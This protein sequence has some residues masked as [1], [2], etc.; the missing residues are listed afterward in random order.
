MQVKGRI[1]PYPVLNNNPVFSG[2][3]TEGFNLNYEAMEDESNYTLKGLTFQTESKI[4][5][6]LFKEKN[7]NLLDCGMFLYR[8]S[9]EV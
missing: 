2:F 3:K 6:E 4:I 1:F 9:Q 5:N 7:R 8:L